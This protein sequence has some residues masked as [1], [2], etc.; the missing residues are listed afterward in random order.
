V[1]IQA[2]PIARSEPF[3]SVIVPAYNAAAYVGEALASVAAQSLA[4]FECIVVDDGSTDATV[5]IA[6]SCGDE[7]FRV[8]LIDHGGC[9]G[10]ARNVGI[11]AATGNYVAFLDADDLWPREKL[12]RFYDHIR[13][14]GAT[15]V[16]SNGFAIDEHGHR[17]SELLS[18]RM[19]PVFPPRDPLLVLSNLLPLASVA[20]RR[21]V[22]L[23]QPFDEDPAMRGSEDYILW[24]KVNAEHE[25]HYLADPLLLYRCHPDQIH[26]DGLEQLRKWRTILGDDDVISA[27]GD[28]IVRLG[29]ELIELRSSYR[30]ADIGDGVRRLARLTRWLF[31]SQR[32]ALLAYVRYGLVRRAWTLLRQR[33]SGRLVGV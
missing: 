3:F 18:R 4:D 24:L 30:R 31:T 32:S 28:G 10:R 22:V 1:S 7:R 8:I 25:L 17:V 2:A 26:R 21:T 19:K 15:L 16:F 13:T 9:P 6:R 23:E 14:T 27:Y 11:Q 12:R 33:L 29:L 20:L 5:E